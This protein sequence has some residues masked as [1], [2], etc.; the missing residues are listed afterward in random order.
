M[1]FHINISHDIF[2][3]Q[4]DIVGHLAE[5]GNW[6][7]NL[8]E[9]HIVLEHIIANCKSLKSSVSINVSLYQNSGAKSIQQLA[10]ALSHVN[11]YL[12]HFG[13]NISKSI[14]FKNAIGSNYFFE[15]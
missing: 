11:E 7:E 4:I 1:Q 3:L 10:Y 12:N 14:V 6:L 15:I 13:E 5:S 2:Y 9:D 8:K